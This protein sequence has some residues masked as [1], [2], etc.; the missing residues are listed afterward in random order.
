VDLGSPATF[1]LPPDLHRGREALKHGLKEVFLGRRIHQGDIQ[2][3]GPSR[4]GT[5][6]TLTYKRSEKVLVVEMQGH[7]TG[8]K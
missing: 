6:L 4:F 5:P 3:V 1:V 8:L 2:C 7:V